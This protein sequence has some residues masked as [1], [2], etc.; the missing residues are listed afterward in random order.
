[1]KKNSC[2]PSN[3]K[4]YSCTGLKKFFQGNADEKIHAARK[5]PTPP[6]P[7][8]A[9]NFTVGPSLSEMQ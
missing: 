1:M 7:P 8:L 6:P 5:F 4:K 9:H 3:P 2:E